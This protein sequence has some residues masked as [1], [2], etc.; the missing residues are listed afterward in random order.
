[1]KLL[2]GPPFDVYRLPHMERVIWGM[3]GDPGNGVFGIP[4]RD[5]GYRDGSIIKVI[6]SSSDGWDHLSVSLELRA[7]WWDEMDW[8]KRLFFKPDEWA[9]QYHASE[10]RHINIHPHVLHIWRKQGFDLPTPPPEFV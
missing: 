4:R 8:V 6:A 5:L 9:W 7:P 1:M 3:P 2:I 10:A